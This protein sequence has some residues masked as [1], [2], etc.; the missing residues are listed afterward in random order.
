MGAALAIPTMLWLMPAPA[1]A[2]NA[3]SASFESKPWIVVS[4]GSTT[5]LGDCDQCENE[6]Y[7]HG[8]HVRVNAGASSGRTDLA[9]KC[10]GSPVTTGDKS[11]WPS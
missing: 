3:P 7:L 4:G 10:S 2:Q 11:R 1:A 8:G 6:N 9:F 5:M